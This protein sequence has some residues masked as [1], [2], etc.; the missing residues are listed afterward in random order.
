MDAPTEGEITWEGQG[1]MSPK[2]WTKLRA[3]DIGVIF[4]DFLL[5]P[6]LTAVQNVQMA[7]GLVRED[8]HRARKRAVAA[9]EMV[10]LAHRLE[11]LPH[12][13]SGGERQRVAI[14]R[15]LINAPRLL[16]V[17]EPTGSLDSANAALVSKLLFDLQANLGH[18]LVLVT[19]DPELARRCA[20]Q[21]HIRD[22]Q[23]AEA[24]L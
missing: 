15:G 7:T 20:R 18:A 4:Q 11:H 1:S 5:L 6:N 13:L 8:A 23:I 16:L 9:L 10:G 3:R 17:D 14:A 19:H 24:A 22:G 12:K 21:I 2:Q